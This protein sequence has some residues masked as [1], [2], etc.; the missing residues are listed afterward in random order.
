METFGKILAEQ[1]RRRGWSQLRL[2]QEADLSQRHISFL[3]TGRAAPGQRAL[4]RL[5]FALAIDG[6]EANALLSAAGMRREQKRLNWQDKVLRPVRLSIQRHLQQSMPWPAYALTIDGGILASNAAV[7]LLLR[8]V[9]PEEDLWDSAGPKGPNI[10]DLT[11]HPAGIS[12]FLANPEQV[13]PAVLRRLRK[14]ALIDDIASQTLQRVLRYPIVQQ[15]SLPDCPDSAAP[16]ILERYYIKDTLASFTAMITHF[17]S[18]E[19]EMVAGI[20]IETLM[21]ADRETEKLLASLPI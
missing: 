4:T 17:G 15:S 16:L 5:L 7:D 21:P 6:Y 11:F 9:A 18:N 14:A 8:W 19:S 10:F 20:G 12:R 2:A 1:R 13:V 3:E